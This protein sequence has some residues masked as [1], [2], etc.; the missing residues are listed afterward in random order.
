MGAAMP[1][2]FAAGFPTPMAQRIFVH[3]YI[4]RIQTELSA[5]KIY[6]HFGRRNDSY[7]IFLIALMCLAAQ[8]QL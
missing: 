3:P 2:Y 7:E 4:L 5:Y 6:I 1:G 8:G